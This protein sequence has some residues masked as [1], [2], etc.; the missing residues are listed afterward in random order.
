MEWHPGCQLGRGGCGNCDISWSRYCRCARWDALLA[1]VA[2]KPLLCNGGRLFGC[3]FCWAWLSTVLNDSGMLLHWMG[4]RKLPVCSCPMNGSGWLHCVVS[5]NYNAGLPTGLSP[6]HNRTVHPG[7]H[8]GRKP[9]KGSPQH[10]AAGGLGRKRCSSARCHLAKK[11]LPP[12]GAR[13]AQKHQS[14]RVVP[15]KVT[16]PV[17]EPLKPSCSPSPIVGCSNSFES[18]QG[19]SLKFKP[20][21]RMF[22]ISSPGAR[23]TKEKGIRTIP[24]SVEAAELAAPVSASNSFATLQNSEDLPVC[25]EGKVVEGAQGDAESASGSGIEVVEDKLASQPPSVEGGVSR[26]ES[27]KETGCPVL[28]GCIS[29]QCLTACAQSDEDLLMVEPTIHAETGGTISLLSREVGDSLGPAPIDKS[30][31]PRGSRMMPRRVVVGNSCHT[32]SSDKD[33]ESFPKKPIMKKAKEPK[34][35]KSLSPK[36]HG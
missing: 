3:V 5:S 4:R 27:P 35:K 15:S 29:D 1:E 25:L 21:G 24:G 26:L 10:F 13:R 22:P 30:L 31:V 34:K 16:S 19:G 9:G 14:S 6:R 28:A 23:S 11:P 2:S 33:G 18:L 17:K 20:F 36:P 32:G 8:H 7:S 12:G